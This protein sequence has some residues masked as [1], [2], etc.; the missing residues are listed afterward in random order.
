[1]E[2]VLEF[3]HGVAYN[4]ICK[5]N[6]QALRI[7]ENTPKNFKGS[8]ILSAPLNLQDDGQLFMI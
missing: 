8:R 4:I 2:P 3:P 5:A 7:K 1:M 6:D